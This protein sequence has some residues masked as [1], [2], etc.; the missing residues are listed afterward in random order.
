M[1]STS[2]PLTLSFQSGTNIQTHHFYPV[3]GEPPI[4]IELVGTIGGRRAT[5]LSGR[6]PMLQFEEPT[7]THTSPNIEPCLDRRTIQ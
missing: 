3:P 6:S 5:I 1:L 2:F 7:D 4:K